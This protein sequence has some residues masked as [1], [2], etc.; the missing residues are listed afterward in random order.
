MYTLVILICFQR[1]TFMKKIIK[2][3]LYLFLGMAV[4]LVVGLI[5]EGLHGLLTCGI[6][7]FCVAGIIYALLPESSL[8]KIITIISFIV[9]FVL[10]VLLYSYVNEEYSGNNMIFPILVLSIPY[11][12]I[13]YLLVEASGD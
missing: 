12:V 4:S 8:K 6:V 5:S 2:F 3:I 10:Y 9:G 7:G 11:V 1:S 13:S